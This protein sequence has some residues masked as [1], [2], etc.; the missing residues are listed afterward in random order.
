MGG[1]NIDDIKRARIIRANYT[2][3]IAQYNTEIYTLEVSGRLKYMAISK[4]DYPVVGDYVFFRETNS[5][6]G[7]IERI[8]ER[9][10]SL[11]RLASTEVFDRQ[12]LA[13]NVDLILICMAMN[14]DFNMTKL[15]HFIT[16][17]NQQQIPYHIVLTKR[18]LCENETELV[19]QVRQL[20]KAPIDCVSIYSEESIQLL[21]D[22]IDTKT[23][24]L[25]GSSGVGKSSITN[26]IIKEDILETKEIRE[27]DAQ[28]RH[29]TSHRELILTKKGGSI[30]D[31][32]GIRIIQFFESDSLEEQFDDI[33]E[34]AKDC[35]FRD[36]T[37]SGEPGC[38]VVEAIENGLLDEER[39]TQYFKLVKIN[40]FHKRQKEIQKLKYEKRRS[41]K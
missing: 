15:S 10:N 40:N 19:A 27:S 9:V 34:L 1:L 8:E 28:G 6:E 35:R 12:V 30:I 38:T 32:P 31:T 37:H 41:Q 21:E 7:I 4:A 25:L 18:D 13:A 2:N 3:Y 29:T 14:K 33:H 39:L 24:V 17:A 36:C 11:D 23:C 26:A 5:N 20:T 16:L 22:I